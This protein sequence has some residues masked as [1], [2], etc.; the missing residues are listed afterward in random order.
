MVHN[1]SEQSKHMVR[2]YWHRKYEIVQT[3]YISNL[4]NP[5]EPSYHTI[6][7]LFQTNIN[8]HHKYAERAENPLLNR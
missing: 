3:A 5:R 8:H 1:V 7:I 6:S 4:L 2:I